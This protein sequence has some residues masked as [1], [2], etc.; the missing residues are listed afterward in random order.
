M[1]RRT[2]DYDRPVPQMGAGMI[3]AIG[4]GA[5][6]AGGIAMTFGQKIEQM[7]TGRPNSLVPGMTLARLV[8]KPDSYKTSLNLPMH[9]MEVCIDVLYVLLV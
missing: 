1:S 8:G 9:Y 2:T 4:L 6:I 5:G 7:F 3:V